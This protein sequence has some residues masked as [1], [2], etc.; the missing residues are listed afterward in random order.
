MQLALVKGRILPS[1]STR[2]L[3]VATCS[4]TNPLVAQPPR[5]IAPTKIIT[6]GAI[7]VTV[8][9]IAFIQWLMTVQPKPSID[10]PTIRFGQNVHL[11]RQADDTGA[12]LARDERISRPSARTQS[13]AILKGGWLHLSAKRMSGWVV[14]CEEPFTDWRPGSMP[15]IDRYKVG[16]R[17][18]SFR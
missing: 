10:V 13:T 12:A 16:T 18:P 14:R 1:A 5:L 11:V 2:W 15:L 8:G 7:F 4:L 6:A 3:T 9:V 17:N